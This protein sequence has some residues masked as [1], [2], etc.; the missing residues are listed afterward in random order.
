MHWVQIVKFAAR[1][2]LIRRR[3]PGRTLKQ[4][5]SIGA[6]ENERLDRKGIENA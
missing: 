5:E 1:L 6:V 3:A 2:P 4:C